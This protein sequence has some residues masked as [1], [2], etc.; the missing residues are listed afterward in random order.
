ML[1]AS[2]LLAAEDRED[3][4]HHD[5]A[6]LLESGHPFATVDLAVYEVTN[7][8]ELRWRDRAAAERLRERIWLIELYGQLLRVDRAL[9]DDAARLVA[10]RQLGAYVAAYVAA[11]HRLAAPLASC[12]ERD[13]VSTGFA[14]LPGE[15][16]SQA[17]K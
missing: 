14:S 16:L 4:H 11:A 10:D 3:R 8:A 6:R 13:L 12:D 7:V 2:V 1:D 5:A 17:G 9:A 15:A